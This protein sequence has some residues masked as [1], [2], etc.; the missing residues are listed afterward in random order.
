MKRLNEYISEYIVESIKHLP[1]NQSGLVVFDIDDTLVKADQ[2]TIKIIKY[3]DGDK[4]NKKYLSSEEYANDPD[5]QTHKDW[6]DFSEFKNP[7][8]VVTSIIKG[9]PLLK[10]LRILDS[11]VNSG[12]KFCFLTARGCED[13]IIYALQKF[14]KIR[15]TKGELEDIRPYF[16][17]EDSA[18]VND[19]IKG[20]KGE[21]DPEKKGEV[22]KKLCSKFDKVVFVDDDNKNVKF[23]RELGINNLTVIKAWKQ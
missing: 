7:L 18:A 1:P 4:K 16:N 12:Y 11:Y 13:A 9:T 2:K 6:F 19:S 21:N 10:N 20:Y 8:K 14:L 5:V 3:I 15:N 22:L 23:A 17:T